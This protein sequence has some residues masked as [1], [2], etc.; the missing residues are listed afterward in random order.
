MPGKLPRPPVG[1]TC[2]PGTRLSRSVRLVGCRRSMS[3][4]VKTVLAALLS[5]RAWT[6]RLA[7][8]TTSGSLSAWSRVSASRSGVGRSSKGRARRRRFMAVHSFE[9]LH[10]TNVG[11]GLPPIAVYQLTYLS[12][13]HRHRGQAPSH[14]LIRFLQAQQR[15]PFAYRSLDPGFIQAALG[16]H[17]RRLGVFDVHIRQAQMQ[18]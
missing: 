14:I 4:R 13:T 10:K 18:H 7:L 6:W 8:M 1:A 3:S 17:L 16:Q 9:N 5:L 2:T 15:H 12:L 11:G